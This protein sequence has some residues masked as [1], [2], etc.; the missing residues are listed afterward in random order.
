MKYKYIFASLY[1]LIVFSIVFTGCSSQKKIVEGYTGVSGPTLTSKDYLKKG[2]DLL[3]KK[4]FQDALTVLNK[5][6]ELDADNGEA[7]AF[8]GMAKYQLNDFKGALADYDKAVSLIPDFGEVYDLRGIVKS[9]LG[10]KVGACEDWNKS[11]D[12]GFNKSYDLIVKYCIDEE[13]KQ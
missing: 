11:F 9:E 1:F 7:Y 2:N 10:D 3:D 4:K 6:I 5:A 12:L 8:R 13:K